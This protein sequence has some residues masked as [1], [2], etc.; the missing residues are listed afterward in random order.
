M[1]SRAREDVL[2]DADSGTWQDL[3]AEDKA[4]PRPLGAA[5]VLPHTSRGDGGLGLSRQRRR[6]LA[7][8]LERERA[9]G[10]VDQ[11][12]PDLGAGRTDADYALVYSKI[13]LPVLRQFR[14]ELILI[15]AGFDAHM[16][17]PLA[18]MRLTSACFG[19]LTAAIAAVADECCEGRL[20]AVT[21]GGYDRAALGDSLRAAIHALEGDARISAMPAGAASRGEAT[22]EAVLP[23]VQD[24]WTL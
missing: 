5:V 13:A 20:V 1:L 14:P 16:D 23:H 8:D 4:A 2:I 15:S 12:M 21:E 7:R 6:L 10:A 11:H 18:G 19:Q 9:I 22:V 24:R 3:D 17:D